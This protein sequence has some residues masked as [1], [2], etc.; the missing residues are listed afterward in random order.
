[1]SLRVAEIDQ[2][3]IAQVLRNI[4][5]KLARGV[6]DGYLEGLD[7]FPIVL[8]IKFSG[9]RGRADQ[10]SEHHRELPA[11]GCRC[12]SVAGPLVNVRRIRSSHLG[13]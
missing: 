2:D 3:S 11:L 9:Q 8:G 1:M 10:V 12:A 5:V 6:G 4:A 13:F 7:E